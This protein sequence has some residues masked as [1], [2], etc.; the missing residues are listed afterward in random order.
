MISL[1]CGVSACAMA[2]TPP[3]ALLDASRA[4]LLGASLAAS[5]SHLGATGAGLGLRPLWAFRLGR[6]RWATGRAS[7]LLGVGRDT[8]DP[9]LST[10]LTTT[11]GWRLSTSL[12]YD[13]GRHSGNDPLLAG[14]PDVPDTVRGRASASKALGPHWGWSISGSQD[15]LGRGGGFN[16]NTGLNY[17]YPVSQQTYWDLGLSAVRVPTCT[18]KPTTACP[19]KPPK[20]A[21][22]CPTS[23]AAAGS[24]CPWAGT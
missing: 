11:N 8:V 23:W 2:Q 18:T 16:L 19:P 24:A 14:V 7:S 1:C 12:R 6:F 15:L 13:K 10:V 4:Y 3:P 5:T 17:R 21:A 22:A 9:G 20:P